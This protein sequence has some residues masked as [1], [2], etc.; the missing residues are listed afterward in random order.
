MLATKTKLYDTTLSELPS[1]LSREL[2]NHNY[3]IT[4][5]TSSK[6]IVNTPASI[7]SWGEEITIEFRTGDAATSITISSDS[8]YQLIDWGKSNGNID[9][10]FLIIDKIVGKS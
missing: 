1:I 6:I 3:K 2:K 5:S 7:W 10:V 8:K 9:N 4:Y